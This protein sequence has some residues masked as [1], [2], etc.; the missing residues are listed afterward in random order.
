MSQRTKYNTAWF[1]L[2]TTA[3]IPAVLRESDPLGLTSTRF[4]RQIGLCNALRTTDLNLVLLS[5][6]DRF[7]R[8]EISSE[9]QR[10]SHLEYPQV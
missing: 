1:M 5:V 3:C 9:R 4:L 2:G 10:G 6:S 7:P 8:S